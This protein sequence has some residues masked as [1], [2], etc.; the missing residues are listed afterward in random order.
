MADLG[1]TLGRFAKEQVRAD[2][3]NKFDKWGIPVHAI[4]NHFTHRDNKNEYAYQ[5]DILIYNSKYVVA[6]EVKN[7]L[8]KDHV[9]EH[10]ERMTKMQE[11]PLPDTKGKILLSAVAGM[12]VGEGVDKYAENKGLFVL[13]PSGDTVKIVNDRKTFKP[14]EWA[15]I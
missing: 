1:D 3:I 15:V 8:K 9:D 14:K 13:K 12:I 5:V 10:L 4:T 11:F 2:L 6:I 7:T